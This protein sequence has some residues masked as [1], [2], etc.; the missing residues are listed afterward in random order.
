MMWS[1]LKQHTWEGR[2]VFSIELID[3][4]SLISWLNEYMEAMTQVVLADGVVVEKLIGDSNRA[5]VGVPIEP[6][7]EEA[8]AI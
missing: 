4:E 3:Q 2:D 5:V 6:I 7:T 8:I 1:K